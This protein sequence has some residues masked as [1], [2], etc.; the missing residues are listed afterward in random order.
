MAVLGVQ[1]DQAVGQLGELAGR[2]EA[3]VSV[4]TGSAGARH[5]PREDE[6]IVVHHEPALHG[7]LLGPGPDD[8][9]VGSVPGQQ[10]DGADQHGLPCPR[11]TGERRHPG[12]EEE[13]DP[14]DHAE[15]ADG[16]LSEHA[17]RV[18]S[19]TAIDREGAWCTAMGRGGRRGG[20][21]RAAPVPIVGQRKAL[22]WEE[23][24][25]PAAPPLCAAPPRLATLRGQVAG[26][27][28]VGAFVRRLGY[29]ERVGL[30]VLVG[31]V[32]RIALA[33]SDDVI[34][35]D[36][37]AYLRSGESLWDGDGFRREGHPELHFPPL[38]PAV[39]GRAQPP[40]RRSAPGHGDRDAGRQHRCCSLV[41]SLAR[42]LGGDRAAVAA[43]WMA[44]LAPGLTDVPVT[45]GSGNEVVF[46][47]LVLAAVRLALLAHDRAG[48]PASPSALAAGSLVGAAYLT[49]PE[50]LLYAPV[51]MA[52]LTAPILVR[53]A[54]DRVSRLLAAGCIGLGLLVLA[55]PYVSYLHSNTGSWEPTAKTNDASIESWQAVADHDR[56]L[57]TR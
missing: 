25:V 31:L 13:R 10:P 51:A 15:V 17:E 56:E 27:S 18:L 39:L 50:G 44:A 21:R 8:G 12:V 6:L 16:E 26:I 11:L 38:Y 57:A 47:L 5:H 23:E 22:T 33:V 46:V 49:R 54:R 2:D 4:G 32:I 36:A 30:A 48:A 19:G 45:S 35:N 42:R 28:H 55:L 53:A 52:I 7:G 41:A 1:V 43:V 29:R 3:A 40:P 20:R 14:V 24:V 34:T 37:S 9:R